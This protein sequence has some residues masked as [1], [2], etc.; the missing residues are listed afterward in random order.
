[1]SLL[2]LYVHSCLNIVFLITVA[3]KCN[4]IHHPL[5]TPCSTGMTDPSY[6]SGVTRRGS[7]GSV[8]WAFLDTRTR[9]I[10]LE[11]SRQPWNSGPGCRKEDTGLVSGLRPGV[12]CAP[13]WGH[14]ISAQSIRWVRGPCCCCC[15]SWDM[16]RHCRMFHTSLSNCAHIGWI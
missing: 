4:S 14:S 10:P 9:M 8:P 7:W 1:M 15:C 5:H 16:R 12:C 3:V 6:S 11:A 13:V 2:F